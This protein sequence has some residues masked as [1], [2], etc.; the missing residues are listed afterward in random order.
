MSIY[1]S[2]SVSVNKTSYGEEL[3]SRFQVGHL[4]STL[5]EYDNFSFYC[6]TP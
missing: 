4:R 3:L 2:S 1:L 5:R 6:A